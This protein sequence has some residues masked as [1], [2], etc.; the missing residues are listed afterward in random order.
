MADN[1][2]NQTF[3]TK[4]AAVHCGAISRSRV[5]PKFVYP[6]NELPRAK[7]AGYQKTGTVCRVDK[8]S[9]STGRKV[10]ALCLSTLLCS[11]IHGQEFERSPI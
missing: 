7:S 3:N 2:H 1:G 6:F 8:H 10:D 11:L 9:A 4:K 5:F